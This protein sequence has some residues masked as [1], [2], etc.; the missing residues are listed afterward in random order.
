MS[1]NALTRA[2]SIS[3]NNIHWYIQLQ[4]CVNAL[5]RVH[6]IST[7]DLAGLW[8]SKKCVSMP[9]IGLTSFLRREKLR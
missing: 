3:T 2:Y 4:R 7:G 9:L 8:K 5:I 1:V 6:V